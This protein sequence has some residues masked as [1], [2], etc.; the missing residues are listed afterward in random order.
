METRPRRQY[1]SCDQCRK[2]K[3][4]C[5]GTVP[6]LLPEVSLAHAGSNISPRSPCSNCTKWRKDCTYNWLSTTPPEPRKK[7]PRHNTAGSEVASTDVADAIFTNNLYQ[8]P[9]GF[10]APSPAEGFEGLSFTPN[11]PDQNASLSSNQSGFT[12]DASDGSGAELDT[13]GQ[14]SFTIPIFSNPFGDGAPEIETR[15]IPTFCQSNAISPPADCSSPDQNTSQPSTSDLKLVNHD[16]YLIKRLLE[17]DDGSTRHPSATGD[18]YISSPSSTSNDLAGRF[19]RSALI[20]NMFRIYHDSMENALSCW[21]AEQ[22]CPYS[23]VVGG[24]GASHGSR[25]NPAEKARDPNWSNRIFSRVVRLDHAFGTS[26]GQKLTATED[27]KASSALLSAI[28]A[29]ASQWATQPSQRAG[30]FDISQS[31]PSEHFSRVNL[32]NQAHRALDASTGTSSFRVIFANIVFSLTQR[33]VNISE[34]ISALDSMTGRSDN[35]MIGGTDD[36]RLSKVDELQ[37]LLDNDYAPQFM[38]NATRQLF[39]FRYK[40]THLQRRAPNPA[41]R[42]ETIQA[43]SETSQS[44]LSPEDNETFNLLFWLGIMF[45][46]LSAAMHQRPPVVSD[47][48]SEIPCAAP[49]STSLTARKENEDNASLVATRRSNLWGD[50]FL[51]QGAGNQRSGITRW[52]CTYAEA[53]KTLCDASPVKVLLFR[54]VSRIQTLIYRGSGPERLEEAIRDALEVYH[55]WNSTY[56]RFILDCTINHD[57]LPPRIQSWYVILAGHWHLAAMILADTLESLDRA[58]IGMESQRECRRAIGLVATLRK[59]NAVAVSNLAY[60]SLRGQDL[61]F[62]KTREFHD[63]VNERAML[64]E[65]WTAVLTRSFTKAGYNLLDEAHAVHLAQNDLSNQALLQC[66]YCVDGLLCLG[67]KSDVALLAARILSSRVDKTLQERVIQPYS[68]P[69]CH[70]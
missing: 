35:Q 27:K 14:T 50:L 57:S 56:K 47:E 66:G 41:G 65:P 20:Q 69:G 43:F 23:V 15:P 12:P 51:H 5:D 26:R 11:A 31:P 40:L 30:D 7:K 39:M 9:F 60:R 59:D 18:E 49:L 13:S 45:D 4:A 37:D 6:E 53:A 21:L 3:R 44:P 67:R 28:M 70:R 10:F 36:T 68:V 19:E 17:S 22:N 33:P 16:D 62:A 38:E 61:S 2:G 8:Q 46:T 54:R 55:H 24:N 25:H 32:W 63:S 52:P 48:D 1:R 58:E 34:H 64:T 29:F 42:M